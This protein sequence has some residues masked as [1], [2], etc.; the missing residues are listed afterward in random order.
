MKSATLIG[1]ALGLIFLYP[2]LTTAA[3]VKKKATKPRLDRTTRLTPSEKKLLEIRTA[4]IERKKASRER[5][6]NSLMDYEE[7]LADQH[8]MH[9]TKKKLHEDNLISNA[10]LAKSE[11]ALTDTRQEAERVRQW[12]SEDD[13]A[14]SLAPEAEMERLPSLSAGSYVETASVIHYNGTARWSPADIPELGNFFQSRFGRPLP[15]SVVGQSLTHDRMGFDHREAVD[16]GVNP[17]SVEGRL[18]MEYLRKAEVPFIAFRGK[19][20]GTSTGAHI[21]VGRPSPRI[22]E[23]KH[24]PKPAAVANHTRGAVER[25]VADR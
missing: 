24:R 11:R 10:E 8:A 14:L 25:M 12:I 17:D 22:Q 16:V 5:L 6:K 13:M 2:V 20:P 15:V 9:E 23:V 21:H 19:I 3:E 1:A 18:L 7:K 4:L